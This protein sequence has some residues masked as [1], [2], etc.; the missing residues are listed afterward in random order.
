MNALHVTNIRAAMRG[1][2][3]QGV[4]Y[5]GTADLRA[6]HRP[7]DPDS[8]IA[9]LGTFWCGHRHA[10][11]EAAKECAKKTAQARLVGTAQAALF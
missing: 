10:D 9:H 6:P 8:W 4:W 5:E 7:E 3:G 11:S 2:P 1:S